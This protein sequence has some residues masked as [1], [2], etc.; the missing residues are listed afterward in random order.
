MDKQTFNTLMRLLDLETVEILG[1]AQFAVRI[2]QIAESPTG[3]L[4]ALF[5]E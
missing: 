3:W 4:A 1:D 2:L 5:E